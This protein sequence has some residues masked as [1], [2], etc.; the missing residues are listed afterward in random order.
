MHFK[1]MGYKLLEGNEMTKRRV[2]LG[3]GILSVFLT[4]QAGAA[5]WTPVTGVET[6]KGFMGG[7]KA[8]RTLANGKIATGEY[9]P[10]GT[11]TLHAWG[12]SI[13]RTWDIVGD[14]QISI[15]ARGETLN[16]QVERNSENLD[17]YRVR[18]MATGE[19]TEFTL[20]ESKAVVPETS[21]S[22]TAK[23]GA[24]A[25][26]SD[27]IAA[28][29]ANPNSAL[30]SLTLKPQY[31]LF[32][33]TL[34]NAGS[35]SSL[36]ILFQ[37]VLP[38]P[39]ENGGKIIWRPAIP[40]IFDQ[41][42]PTGSGKYKSKSGLG[43]IA[44]DLAY[45]IPPRDDGI[46]GAIGLITSLPTGSGELSN[47]NWTLGPEFMLGKMTPKNIFILFPSHQWDIA[48]SGNSISLTSIQAGIVHLA[49]G[50]W[51][52]GSTPQMSY[53]WDA[54]QWTVP[55]NFNFS[56]TVMLGS[57]PWKLGGEINYYV[58]RADALAPEWMFGLSIT[59]VVKNVL[60]DWF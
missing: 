45:A 20:T 42:I 47:D 59:P 21:G 13:A 11:G 17:L 49:G 31:R 14:D 26:S 8:E 40:V 39:L 53:N 19:L 41:P 38:F 60:A 57:R 23:G 48:G 16:F 33:G 4:L 51:T 12:A 27:E 54:E 1:L 22:T 3:I 9:R 25:P 15:T 5:E 58:E 18:D 10:D 2:V 37:P 28:E 35:Q 44:F 24:A 52:I 32:D 50:G 56:K 7:L 30:A 36:T 6:L 34:P 29:L 46:I 55:I 43:D